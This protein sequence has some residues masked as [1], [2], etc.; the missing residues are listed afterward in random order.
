MLKSFHHHEFEKMKVPMYYT[1]INGSASHHCTIHPLEIDWTL[2]E[3]EL[4]EAFRNWLRK[5]DHAPFRPGYKRTTSKIGKRKQAG[6]L[7]YLRELAIYRISEAGITRKDG[8]AML[9]RMKVSPAN[10]EH[11][12]TRT[13]DRIVKEKERCEFFAWDQGQGSPANWRDCFVKPFRL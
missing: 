13:L 6:W 8:L 5:G 1:W 3:T 2:T 12:Q 4:V 10:W 7:A 9:G 11:A